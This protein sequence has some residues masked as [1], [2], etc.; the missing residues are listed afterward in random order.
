MKLLQSTPTI[1]DTEKQALQ[2]DEYQKVIH[3][4][5]G[6]IMREKI[7]D[8]IEVS[9]VKQFNVLDCG[10]GTGDVAIRVA[11]R[12]PKAFITGVDASDFYLNI[13]KSKIKELNLG[14][15][16]NLVNINFQEG[17]P[18]DIERFDFVVSQYVFHYHFFNR[19]SLFKSIY[20]TLKSSGKIIFGVS[21]P[22][23][24][25]IQ[26]NKWWD[27]KEKNA[28]NWY[29]IQ[30][31]DDKTVEAKAKLSRMFLEKYISQNC[32]KDNIEAWFSDLTKAGFKSIECVWKNGMD[33]VIQAIK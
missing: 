9:K 22:L 21:I 5:L 18:E 8:C 24:D 20:D 13:A 4:K 10:T 32:T 6:V 2:Y 27:E 12:F 3:G 1:A 14:D 25:E 29:Q 17:V 16:I 11:K 26:N 7:V 15:R 31:L 23:I 28:F 30:N 33:T 19:K